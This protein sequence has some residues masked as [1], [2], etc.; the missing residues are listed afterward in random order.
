MTK[1]NRPLKIFTG[2]AAATAVVLGTVTY[3]E[4]GPGQK[5]EEAAQPEVIAVTVEP[6]K[7]NSDENP[8]STETKSPEAGASGTEETAPDT[9]ANVSVPAKPA[10]EPVK[11]PEFDTVRVEE[12]GEAIV[13]GSAEPGAEVTIKFNGEVVGKGVANAEGDWVVVPEKPLAP[14]TGELSIE[15]KT[16]GTSETVA[17]DQTVAVA[18]PETKSGNQP[19]VAI[20]DPDEPSKV[21]QTPGPETV[22]E[23]S[24]QPSAEPAPAASTE[25]PQQQQ[26]AVNPA[27]PAVEQAAAPAKLKV[28]LDS[29]DYNDQGDIVFSGR[30]GTG[31]NVR[32]YVDNKP[33]GDARAGTDGKWT[34]TGRSEI[35]PGSHSLRVDQ[36]DQNGKVLNRI[37]LPFMREEPERV[38]ALAEPKKEEPVAAAAPAE[39]AAEAAP[40]T[41]AASTQ[42]QET[43]VAVQTAPEP[44]LPKVGRVVIQPGN[45]LWKLSRVIYGRGKHYTVIYEANREQIRNP[46]RI[47]PGQIFTTPDAR[48]PEKIDPKRKEPLKPEEGGTPLD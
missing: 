6:G 7:Q 43:T 19:M 25:Q 39:P 3:D 23:K 17:S 1:N 10:P 32:I 26:A 33:V 2:L 35:A 47:Y 11:K 16:P 13:A 37:E 4:W 14:G 12:S 27:E 5:T 22:V 40:G 20:L 24:E 36:I 15:Q 30:A 34:W 31:A 9:N 44:E 38:V 28:A 8:A 21:V 29:V 46:N 41:Q 42:Q 18:V 48:P 45:N